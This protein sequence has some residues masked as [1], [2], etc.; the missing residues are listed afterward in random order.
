MFKRIQEYGVRCLEDHELLEVLLFYTLPRVNTNEI[1]HGL[2]NEIESLENFGKADES[3]FNNV[4]GLGARSIVFFSLLREL[5]RRSNAP[6]AT[7]TYRFDSMSK[8]GEYLTEKLSQQSSESFC[9]LFLG[10]QMQLLRFVTFSGGGINNAPIDPRAIARRAAMENA[11]CVIL[12]HNHPGG[13]ATPSE[14]DIAVTEEIRK[15]LR[16]IGVDLI[17]HI[18][19]TDDSYA[20][21]LKEKPPEKESALDNQFYQKFYG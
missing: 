20:P 1:A 9:A 12:A 18:I 3:R 17:E 16:A 14:A 8:V 11:A 4:E 21:I 7:P 13:Y 5:I 10:N 15:C 2:L 19:V 6:S